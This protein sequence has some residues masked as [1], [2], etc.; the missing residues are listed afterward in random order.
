MRKKL[1]NKTDGKWD[2]RWSNTAIEIILSYIPEMIENNEIWFRDN[3][4]SGANQDALEGWIHTNVQQI[5]TNLGL[6][7]LVQTDTGLDLPVI[8]GDILGGGEE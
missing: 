2:I 5:Q 7:N 1:L 3:S 4:Y 8:E 6:N